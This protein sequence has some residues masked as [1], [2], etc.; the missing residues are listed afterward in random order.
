M[1]AVVRE[2]GFGSE[3]SL[4]VLAPDPLT[5]PYYSLLNS[6]GCSLDWVDPPCLA[7]STDGRTTINAFTAGFL[8]SIDEFIGGWTS[9]LELFLALRDEL[10]QMRRSVQA[11]DF[12]YA[13]GIVVCLPLH[14]WHLRYTA[15]QLASAL[16]SSRFY[17]LSGSNL[18]LL[19]A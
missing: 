13:C 8:T 3:Q 17:K 14:M 12:A 4:R 11:W 1:G 5:S 15:P 7:S 18:E 2:F 10:C 6:E 19:S 9:V 16:L